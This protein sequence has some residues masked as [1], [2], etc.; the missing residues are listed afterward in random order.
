MGH[1]TYP[2][3]L[4]AVG[5]GLLLLVAVGGQLGGMAVVV[6]VDGVNIL[7]EPAGPAAV[8][9]VFGPGCGGTGF[10]VRIWSRFWSLPEVR[11]KQMTT[12][13]ITITTCSII[14]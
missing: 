5:S 1:V 9:Q 12:I 13:V 3:L 2:S 7:G 11:C 4:A 8:G 10:K 6:S 14:P